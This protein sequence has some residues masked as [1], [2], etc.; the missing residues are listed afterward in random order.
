MDDEPPGDLGWWCISGESLLGALRQVADGDN[1]D[2]V[3]A[4][5]V[6]NSDHQTV[7]D[8]LD[9]DDDDD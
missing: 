8:P 7:P 9:E 4:E 1:P 5:L 2:I 3:Y 6:A